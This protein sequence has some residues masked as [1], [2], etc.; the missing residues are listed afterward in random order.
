MRIPVQLKYFVIL[1]IQLLQERG[2]FGRSKALVRRL[3]KISIAKASKVFSNPDM[4][5]S[6]GGM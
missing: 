5:L 3:L 1:Q 4:S 2:V 6:E